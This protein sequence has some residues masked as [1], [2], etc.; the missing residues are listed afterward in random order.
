MLVISFFSAHFIFIKQ[1]KNIHNT[2][3][4]KLELNIKKKENKNENP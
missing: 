2:K 4:R 1:T 3:T